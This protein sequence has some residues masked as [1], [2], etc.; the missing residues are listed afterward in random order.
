MHNSDRI[1]NLGGSDGLLG[2]EG[3]TE[4]SPTALEKTE[5]GG[6]SARGNM[7]SQVDIDLVL[8]R[9]HALFPTLCECESNAWVHG[10]CRITGCF[11][12]RFNAVDE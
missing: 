1:Q 5:K 12:I 11:S 10:D 9:V 6:R 3:G 8:E 7:R 4:N 2:E